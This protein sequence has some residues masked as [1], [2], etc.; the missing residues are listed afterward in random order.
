[1]A[2]V[3]SAGLLVAMPVGGVGLASAETKAPAA[4]EPGGAERGDRAEAAAADAGEAHGRCRQAARVFATIP[5]RQWRTSAAS[6]IRAAIERLTTRDYDRYL[7]VNDRR[8]TIFLEGA[9]ASTHWHDVTT[10]GDVR[11]RGRRLRLV[12]VWSLAYGQAAFDT[13]RVLSLLAYQR[14][15][16]G[17][18]IAAAGVGLA[19]YVG[20]RTDAPRLVQLDGA[21]YA[22]ELQDD[23][24][25]PDGTARPVI[26]YLPDQGCFRAAAAHDRAALRRELGSAPAAGG[27][28]DPTP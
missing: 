26:Y 3:L 27:R 13:E 10:L 28:A 8:S 6:R 9:T 22:I 16:V 20:P 23:G 7:A 21:G 11:S 4:V 24:Q 5:D 25:R 1:M 14:K 18:D 19:T 12:A 2:I 15:G 17:W